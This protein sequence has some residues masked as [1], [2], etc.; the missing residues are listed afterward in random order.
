MKTH[1]LSP[2]SQHQGLEHNHY[3][4]YCSLKPSFL[5]HLTSITNS[6]STYVTEITTVLY[7]N[8]ISTTITKNTFYHKTTQNI[9]Y[10]ISKH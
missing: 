8:V 6:K 3:L 10:S 4:L 2:S 9:A 7:N 5:F 1:G